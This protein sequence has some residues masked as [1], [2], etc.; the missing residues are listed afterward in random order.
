MGRAGPA[1]PPRA[2][3]MDPEEGVPPTG[4]D[5]GSRK[6]GR[7]APRVPEPPTRGHGEGLFRHRAG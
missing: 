6:K 3:G 1:S 5:Q 2:L 4:Q 7:L